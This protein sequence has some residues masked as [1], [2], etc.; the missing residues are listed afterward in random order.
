METK[1]TVEQIYFKELEEIANQIEQYKKNEIFDFQLINKIKYLAI[2]AY[3]DGKRDG[4][5]EMNKIFKNE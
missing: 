2:A 1:K 5:N 3:Y 4:I